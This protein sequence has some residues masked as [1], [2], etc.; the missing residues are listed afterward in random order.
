MFSFNKAF[1]QKYVLVLEIWFV[2]YPS[3]FKATIKFSELLKT[4]MCLKILL[5][6]EHKNSS[7]VYLHNTVI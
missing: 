6:I 7:I 3:L 5:S 4:L 2:A 1:L